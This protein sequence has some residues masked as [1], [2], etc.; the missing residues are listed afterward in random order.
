M[1]YKEE[2]ANMMSKQG[3]LSPQ[4]RYVK[5]ACSRIRKSEGP[6]IQKNEE[7]DETYKAAERAYVANCIF[8]EL[9]YD[10][11]IRTSYEDLSSNFTPCD[12]KTG[13]CS[14]DCYGK[15]MCEYK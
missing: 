11:L 9:G 2:F 3:I 4:A 10:T 12:D 14:F 1:N 8:S 5:W 6:P 7:A 15:R 13:Q